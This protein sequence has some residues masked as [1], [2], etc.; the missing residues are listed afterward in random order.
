MIDGT[1]RMIFLFEVVGKYGKRTLYIPLTQHATR[2]KV[3]KRWNVDKYLPRGYDYESVQP[4]VT[5]VCS[6]SD[7]SI[8]SRYL[9]RSILNAEHDAVFRFSLR[10]LVYSQDLVLKIVKIT[11]VL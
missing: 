11:R 6:G 10:L 5:F 9:V 1:L 8:L 2:R 3:K 4:D 7:P